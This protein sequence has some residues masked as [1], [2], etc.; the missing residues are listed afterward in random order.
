MTLSAFS[1]EQRYALLAATLLARP[2]VSVGACRKNALVSSA[3]C[4]N[5]RTFAML[6]SNEEFVVKLPRYR[7]TGLVAAGWGFHFELAHGRVMTGWFVA[8]SAL[9]ESWMSLAEEALWFVA[10]N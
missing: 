4:V 6:S 5:D 9:D 7:V 10:G 8:G 1:A 2:G 3:L